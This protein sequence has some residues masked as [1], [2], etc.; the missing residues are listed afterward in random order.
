MVLPIIT[1]GN[2]ILRK[3]CTD[4]NKETPGLNELIENLWSTLN[5][6]NGVGLASP[7]INSNYKVFIV[8]ST[9]VYNKLTDLERKAIFTEDKGIIETF[10]NARI[11]KESEEK[12]SGLEECLSI[13]WI[14]EYVE[15]ACDITVEYQDKS[16]ITRRNQFSGYTAKV[17]QHEYDHTNGILFIDH[18][19]ALKKRMLSSK[20]SRIK[21]GNALTNYLTN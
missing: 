14:I 5:S 1:Y 12:W 19:S 16:F 10:I 4:V 15:R 21:R 3:A 13:P 9:H 11:I 17:I 20:L 6:L 8:N 7:Q 18:L 2:S